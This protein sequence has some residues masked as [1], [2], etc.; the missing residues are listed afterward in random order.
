M[1]D[2]L[3]FEKDGVTYAKGFCNQ[4]GRSFYVLPGYQG[5]LDEALKK[6]GVNKAWHTFEETQSLPGDEAL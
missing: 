1:V 4:E 3:R 2:I 6:V 5:I